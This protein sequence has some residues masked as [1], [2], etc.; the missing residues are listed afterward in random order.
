MLQQMLD[1]NNKRRIELTLALEEHT[2]DI[3]NTRRA[4]EKGL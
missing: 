1:N 2:V 3:M 4:I